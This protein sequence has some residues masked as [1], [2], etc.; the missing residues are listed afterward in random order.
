MSESHK[1]YCRIRGFFCHKV[2]LPEIVPTKIGPS[3]GT[4]HQIVRIEEKKKR[5][6]G[7][8]LVFFN[9]AHILV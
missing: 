6:G 3:A 2:I 1:L 7:Y 9:N 5:L 8:E 4:V